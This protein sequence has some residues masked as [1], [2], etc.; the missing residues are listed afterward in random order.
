MDAKALLILLVVGCV[1]GWLAGL[2]VKKGG[3]GLIGNIVVG[4]IGSFLGGWL[5]PMVGLKI[6]GNEWVQA[7]VTATIGAIVLL[8]ALGLIRKVIK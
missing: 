7:I 3:F 8:L 2:V 6:P 1:A 5:L 4:V